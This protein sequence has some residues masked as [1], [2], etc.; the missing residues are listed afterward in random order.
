M[1]PPRTPR[2]LHPTTLLPNLIHRLPDLVPRNIRFGADPIVVHAH[3]QDARFVV[4]EGVRWHA[5]CF[6][7]V[8][9]GDGGGELGDAEGGEELRFVVVA[10][11]RAFDA[12]GVGGWRGGEEEEGKG[13]EEGGWEIHCFVRGS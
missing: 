1:I 6:A 8:L 4:E 10:P 9:G 5:R 13:E 12:L 3:E 7:G 2:F 11:C